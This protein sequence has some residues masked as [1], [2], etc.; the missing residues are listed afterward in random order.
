MSDAHGSPPELGASTA[1]E[2]EIELESFVVEACEF[3]RMFIEAEEAAGHMHDPTKPGSTVY[4]HDECGRAEGLEPVPTS[5]E[6]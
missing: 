2:I 1:Q 6:T 3:C 5:S 4:C